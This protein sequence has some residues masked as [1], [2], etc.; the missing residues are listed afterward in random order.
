MNNR[1]EWYLWGRRVHPFS[2]GVWIAITTVAV[3]LGGGGVD[4][5]GYVFAFD[6]M[7]HFVGWVSIASSSL[8]VLGFLANRWVFLSWGIMLATAVFVARFALYW[9]DV[10]YDSFPMWISFGLAVTSIGAWM[11]ERDRHHG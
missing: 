7:A 5:G 11:L 10:G 4:A 6:E 8:F 1:Q 9:M 3:Y 2:W